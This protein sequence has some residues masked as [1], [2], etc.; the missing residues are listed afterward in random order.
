MPDAT[1]PA[2]APPES[3]TSAT[4]PFQA[5]LPIAVIGAGF[6]GTMTALHL[7]RR[8]AGRRVLLC[9][10]G[11][12]FAQ[13]AAYGT[14]DPVHLL[15]VRAANMSAFPAQ[16]AH[17]VEWLTAEAA[18]E[19]DE[20]GHDVERHSHE[21]SAGRFVSRTLYGRYL[22]SLLRSELSG[23][24]GASR[25]R[26]V[27]EEAAALVRRPCGAFDLRLAGGRVH[28]V[29]A[30]V[31][32]VG[33][34]AGGQGSVPTG[35]VRDPWSAR[36]R[37]GLVGDRPVL[38][39]GTGLSMV[40][41]ATSLASHGFAGPVIAFSRHGLLPHTHATAAPWTLSLSASAESEPLS[42]LL[43][44]VR[45]EV[46][47]AALAG[48][49]WQSV[50]DALRPI[51][52]ALWRGMDAERQERF[53]RHLRAWWDVHRHRM[54]P[55]VAGTIEGLIRDGRLRVA[56]GQILA[57]REGDGRVVVRWR[58]RGSGVAEDLEVQRVIYA[59]GQPPMAK[60]RDALL[61]GLMEAGL[62]RVDRHGLGLDA[63]DD[64]GLIGTDGRSTDGLWGVGPVVRGAF[65]E[66]TA[67][68]DIR[69]DAERLAARIAAR[70]GG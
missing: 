7:L 48:L 51:T 28:R 53:I 56:A 18:R 12:T 17:L 37:E 38:I 9:E 41:V 61:D 43:R 58:P 32:A 29:A 57:A 30:A 35:I 33:N 69:V 3:G 27:P 55:P 25:L 59:T 4:G 2:A 14:R 54:A 68:P 63:G 10:R 21:T 1:I 42:W 31:L 20:G 49:P 64:L 70:L 47:A 50:V 16:P 26:I 67:V 46:E 22:S 6:S 62:I 40:D 45:R 36:F 24:E 19:A 8:L 44:K 39:V 66:C 52:T 34:P 65:W 11:E 15:N 60:V 23:P 5:G 13:G